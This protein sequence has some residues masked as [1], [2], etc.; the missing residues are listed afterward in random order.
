MTGFLAY[1]G[2]IIRGLLA[3]FFLMRGSRGEDSEAV[4]IIEASVDTLGLLTAPLIDNRGLT[5]EPTV[6][7]VLYFAL[8]VV[9]PFARSAWAVESALTTLAD[10]P[11]VPAR[12]GDARLLRST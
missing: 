9:L 1:T 10:A 2:M 4:P 7:F 11:M 12:R 3:G 5:D 6:Q 8:G